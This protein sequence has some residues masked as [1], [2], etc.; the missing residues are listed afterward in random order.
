MLS[1]LTR[2]ADKIAGTRTMLLGCW[3]LVSFKLWQQTEAL[4]AEVIGCYV[5]A[6]GFSYVGG[7]F[8]DAKINVQSTETVNASTVS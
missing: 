6:F 5:G 4:S 7:K 3:I 1:L 2:F 8:A